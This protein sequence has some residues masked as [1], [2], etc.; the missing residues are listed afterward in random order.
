M[1][2]KFMTGCMTDLIS[3]VREGVSIT[4]FVF[5]VTYLISP[6]N[7]EINSDSLVCRGHLSVLEIRPVVNGLWY[8]KTV[9]FSAEFRRT[10]PCKQTQ[11]F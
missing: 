8:V 6:V 9:I 1:L 4:T 10:N 3:L 2:F 7:A 11:A 5:P